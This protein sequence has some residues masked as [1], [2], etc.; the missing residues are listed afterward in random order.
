MMSKNRSVLSVGALAIFANFFVLVA[1]GCDGNGPT[2]P[3]KTGQVAMA[4]RSV[5]S[6]GATYELRSATI[7]IVG[8]QTS[9]V[10]TGDVIESSVQNV[11]LAI[12]NYLARLESGWVLYRLSGGTEQA[13]MGRLIS[14]NPLLFAI[15]P[16]AVTPVRFEFQVTDAR[17]VFAP[18]TA[19]IGIV[20]G[21]LD[22]GTG[23]ADAGN[24]QS[25]GAECRSGSECSTG[26]CADGVCCESACGGGGTDCVA[27]A[28]R[29]TGRPD[30][31]CAPAL[32]GST[33]R[34]AR[35]SC[36]IGEVCDGT[37]TVCPGDQRVSVGIVCR[38]AANLCDLAETCDGKGDAC[39]VN[40]VR[41][42]GFVCRPRSP[43]VTCDADDVCDGSSVVCTERFAPVT[44]ACG[45]GPVGVCDAPDHCAG[46]S[47][48][49]VPTYLAGV[50]C[51]SSAGACDIAEYCAGTSADCPPNNVISAGI[52]C[53]AAA[54]TC[55]ITESCDGVSASCP[56]DVLVASG[57]VCRRSIA[58]CDAT[59]SCN[60]MSASCP[61]DRVSPAGT[62][63]RPSVF[64][65]D[66][67]EVCGGT[68]N[69]C[70]ADRGCPQAATG[71]F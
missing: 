58:V 61:V 57:T 45:A 59:E 60:G 27:C 40:D 50:E 62:M 15:N 42:A 6:D 47:S 17:V 24:C 9:L 37:S 32:S 13:V 29:S 56:A 64:S 66:P 51:R 46:T 63:C 34:V 1:A 49:C 69:S 65:C 68:S 39:P 4:L 35:G 26:F 25:I 53:R 3:S 16:G 70:P 10:R 54:G 67:A 7:N 28:Q 5:G 22:A 71:L 52:A 48:D 55:D 33:C 44:Q 11:T 31:V 14:D 43:G 18:G 8:P 30:G 2:P 36:D 23:C 19:E 21:I 20:V 41:R 38:D 12:G